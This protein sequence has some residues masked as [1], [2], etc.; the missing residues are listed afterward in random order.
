MVQ[1]ELIKIQH[2]NWCYKC[3][4]DTSPMALCQRA[5]YKSTDETIL[6]V[7]V[8]WSGQTF[9]VEYMH[10]GHSLQF[11]INHPVQKK[12]LLR[13][14]ETCKKCVKS[15]SYSTWAAITKHHTLGGL[16]NRKL[17]LTVL[18]AVKFKIK[19]PANSV[20]GEDPLFGLQ[21]ATFLYPYL[22]GRLSVSCIFL[23]GH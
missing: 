20:L 1:I 18:E 11:S 14:P 19:V 4:L 12:E 21:M 15:P 17:F 22:M 2:P 6:S 3:C 23:K 16:T 8:H 13:S 7:P 5:S 10:F 9:Q